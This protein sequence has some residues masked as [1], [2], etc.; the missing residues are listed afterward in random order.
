M[1][2]KVSK[3]LRRISKTLGKTEELNYYST[4]QAPHTKVL[5][6][7]CNRAAYK[8]LKRSLKYV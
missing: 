6:P 2:G 3:D 4:R 8:A 7:D 1:R 5:H